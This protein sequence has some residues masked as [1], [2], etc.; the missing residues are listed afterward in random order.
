MQREDKLA[1]LVPSHRSPAPSLWVNE[2]V[3]PIIF[4]RRQN[5]GGSL[6]GAGQCRWNLL[7]PLASSRVKYQQSTIAIVIGLLKATWLD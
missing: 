3:D 7:L 5:R 1:S 4:I 2:Q 6:N